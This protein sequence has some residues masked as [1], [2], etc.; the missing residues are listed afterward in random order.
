MLLAMGA[1]GRCRQPTRVTSSATRRGLLAVPAV[2]AL[3]EAAA[4]ATVAALSI[5]LAVAPAAAEG[6][7]RSLLPRP[8]FEALDSTVERERLA[9]SA[10][11]VSLAVVDSGKIV[12]E[13]GYG[14]GNTVRRTRV[15]PDM[16]FRAGSIQKMVTAT[17]ALQL[18]AD[19]IVA[20]DRPIS[21]Y[22]PWL[23]SRVGALHIQQ[24][25]TQTSG[26]RDEAREVS[27][28]DPDM[29]EQ[30]CRRLS[31]ADGFTE[32]GPI[33]SYSNLGYALVGCVL[34]SAAGQPFA[35]LVAD[36]VLIPLGMTHS[37]LNPLEAAVGNL[38]AGHT[39]S[40]TGPQ[41]HA[42][43]TSLP[44]YASAGEL[45]STASDLARFAIAVMNS[46]TPGSKAPLTAQT[47]ARLLRPEV[48]ARHWGSTELGRYGMGLFHREWRGRHIVEH[49]GL[50]RGFAADLVMVPAEG[51]AVVVMANTR[52]AYFEE[53]KRR[54]LE[55]A[56]G[57]TPSPPEPLPEAM[58]VDSSDAIGV[59]G[60]GASIVTLVDRGGRLTLRQGMDER[61]L[62]QAR[63]DVY[64]VP[65][66]PGMRPWR[67]V[68]LWILRDAAGRVIGINYLGRAQP[69]VGPVPAA[70]IEHVHPDMS[71]AGIGAL[72][73]MR[74]P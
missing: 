65:D 43:F 55:I 3:S 48:D 47:A 33:W 42:V 32:F 17:L 54:A 71:D 56:L 9:L 10:A 28:Y 27:A 37:T 59:Y 13:K 30:T 7:A 22:L 8:S 25:L 41:P 14:F 66:P 70:H 50:T 73:F 67:A 64:E 6:Q 23:P 35:E 2:D 20:L 58:A 24:L 62:R 69:R 63:A 68:T 44:G 53:T 18:A 36:R 51:V 1:D 26:L 31:D 39:W 57:L 49:A 40:A 16:L 34:Q 21:A 52:A 45:I 11:G 15:T 46:N 12:Y 29:L 72:G 5:F 60:A 4:R 19:G 61:A 74:W 38:A